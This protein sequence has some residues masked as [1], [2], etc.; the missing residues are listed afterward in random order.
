MLEFLREFLVLK[1]L[2]LVHLAEELA[3]LLCNVEDI[4]NGF[5]HLSIVDE[6]LLNNILEILVMHPTDFLKV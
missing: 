6:A 1:D 2:F 3:H 5:Q 4:L